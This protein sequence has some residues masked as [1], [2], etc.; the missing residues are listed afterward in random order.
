MNMDLNVDFSLP[1]LATDKTE[2]VQTWKAFWPPKYSPEEA[3][4]L[5]KKQPWL[6]WKPDPTDPSAEPW[7]EWTRDNNA[8]LRRS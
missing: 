2:R 8:T 5:E 6:N 7:Q 3:R 1:G 4:E